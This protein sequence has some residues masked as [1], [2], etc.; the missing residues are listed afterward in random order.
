[1][2]GTKYE[3]EATCSDCGARI[4]N[5]DDGGKIHWPSPDGPRFVRGWACEICFE[6][7]QRRKD[8]ID[9]KA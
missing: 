3:I 9:L 6:K 1:M 8:R 7:R 5:S 2:A 4:K